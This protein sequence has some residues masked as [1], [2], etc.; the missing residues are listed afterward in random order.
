MPNAIERMTRARP[1]HAAPVRDIETVEFLLD[2]A[3]R[4]AKSKEPEAVEPPAPVESPAARQA[5]LIEQINS[6][7]ITALGVRRGNTQNPT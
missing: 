4:L 3:E 7:R 1:A 2:R 6:G 5:R